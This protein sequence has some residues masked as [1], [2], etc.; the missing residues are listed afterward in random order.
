MLMFQS[1]NPMM[2]NVRRLLPRLVLNRHLLQAVVDESRPSC[3]L[4][5]VEE[6]KHVLPL[7]ALGLPELEDLD[8]LGNGFRLGHQIAA[9]SGAEALL[10]RFEFQE[11]APLELLLDPTNVTVQRVLGAIAATDAY[12]VLV[13]GS[14]GVTTFRADVDGEERQRFGELCLRN[15][16]ATTR[17]DQFAALERALLGRSKVHAQLVWLGRDDASWLDLS[18]AASYELRPAR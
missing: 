4:G 13:A 14:N 2:T 18:E 3:A 1:P 16:L 17:A 15:A 10:L 5:F 12:F 9:G 8:L 6:R 11:R 7:I